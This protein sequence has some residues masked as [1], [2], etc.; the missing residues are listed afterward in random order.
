M[1]LDRTEHIKLLD[2]E[3]KTQSDNYL[4][5][6]FQKAT[7]LIEK[8]EVFTS[9]FVKFED[10]ILVLKLKTEKA[11]PRKGQYLTSVLL[12][13]EKRSYKDWGDFSWAELRNK[14]QNGFTE[15]LLNFVALVIHLVHLL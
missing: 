14:Y 7:S 3:L 11:I 6:V 5:L 10:G 1:Q 2:L 8:E 13:D 15:Y 12:N 4:K 9:Q